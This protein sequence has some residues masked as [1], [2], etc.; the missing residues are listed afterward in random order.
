VPAPRV[1]I[2]LGV[3]AAAIVLFVVLRPGADETAVPAGAETAATE[4][5]ET[6]PAPTEPEAL[7]AEDEAEPAEE[8]ESTEEPAEPAVPT[9][10]IVVRGGVPEGGIQRLTVQQGEEVRIVVRS[11]TA[12][13]LHLH[14]YDLVRSVGPGAPAQMR[15]RATIPGRFELETH[16]RH[17]LIGEVEVRP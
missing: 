17:V 11:D 6:A 14:G 4:P 8:P 2:G 13:E 3:V 10:S 15:F 9:L 1:L 7:P 16:T 5:G 12:D